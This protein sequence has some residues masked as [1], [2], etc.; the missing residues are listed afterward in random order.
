MKPYLVV[1]LIFTPC[2]VIAKDL[3]RAELER[4]FES[5]D[6]L[7]R[8]ISTDDVNEGELQFLQA[9]PDRTVHHHQNKLMIDAESVQSGWVKL[10]QCHENL[11]RVPRAQILYSK[12]RIK[13]LQ[14]VS[15]ENIGE[16][17]IEDNSVQ[18]RNIHGKARLCVVARTR[19]LKM[20]EDGIYVLRNG[21]FMRRFLDGYYP[22]WV[23]MEIDFSQSDLKL[24][25]MKPMAQEGFKVKKHE[26][27]I[28]YDAWFE[29]KL[30]TEFRFRTR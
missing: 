9:L 29:G 16:S 27:S 13:E 15:S 3:D 4:W 17:W 12:E 20:G 11:D 18:L 1:L 30:S 8:S 23:S 6:V 10:H 25:A 21:P 22:M 7:P 5:D 26:G 14:V 24:I 2:L 28:S 19:A